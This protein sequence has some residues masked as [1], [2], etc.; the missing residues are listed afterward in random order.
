MTPPTPEAGPPG[1]PQPEAPFDPEARPR[2]RR[3]HRIAENAGKE[4]SVVVP[5][6][7]DQPLGHGYDALND[8][9]GDMIVKGIVDAAKVSRLA[10]QNAAS[11]AGMVLTTRRSSPTC[12]KESRAGPATVTT[13]TTSIGGFGEP[14]PLQ[15][16]S[17]QAHGPDGRRGR[18]TCGSDGL[19][20]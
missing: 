8:L 7:K 2:G 17:R 15:S 11:I 10:L 12:Q 13:T 4:G 16:R 1:H 9:Y 3:V 5:A 6:V 14:G 19:V 20:W 18:S